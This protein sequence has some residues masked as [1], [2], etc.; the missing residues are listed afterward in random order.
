M[1]LSSAARTAPDDA[2]CHD[3][4]APGDHAD[5]V[6]DDA[7][8]RDDPCTGHD[9]DPCNGDDARDGD[10]D[11]VDGRHGGGRATRLGFA[12]APGTRATA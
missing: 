10:D 11:A 1:I 8:V 12:P 4:A 7:A 2:G 3:H 5:T 6:R 9:D